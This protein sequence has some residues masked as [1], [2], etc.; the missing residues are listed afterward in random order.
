MNKF[1]IF[2]NFIELE[3]KYFLF[4][5]ANGR[6]IVLNQMIYDL[7]NEN[8][9]DIDN[10]K[11]IHP[12]L[13]ANLEKTGMIVSDDIDENESLISRLENEEN[14][15]EYF[16]IIINPTLDCNLRCWYC[17]ETHGHGTMMSTDVIESIKHLIDRKLEGHRLKHFNIGF[18]GGEPLLGWSKVV[19]PILTYAATK[20]VERGVTL[21]SSFTT[22]GVLLSDSKFDELSR[23]G[24]GGTSFQI[25]FD[26]H[27]ALHDISRIADI[28]HPT[29]DRIMENVVKGAYKGFKMNLRFNYT[30]ENID[31]F[32]NIITELE[33]LP[34]DIITHIACNFQQVWQTTGDT[35]VKDK[36]KT[37]IE[38]FRSHGIS[39]SSDIIYHRHVCYAD[40]PRNVVI[41]FNGDVYKCTAREFSSD[42]REGILTSEGN[43]EWNN[44]F[45]RRMAI[46][47]SNQTCRKC[48][49]LP[50]C[51]A[52]CS[53]N[54]LEREHQNGCPNNRTISSK[55]E[56]II[57]ALIEKLSVR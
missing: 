53:Q 27:R 40:S 37:L 19:M 48:E 52:G 33:R 41:N 46:K 45:H 11:S 50:I 8:R 51:N 49:I 28:A 5:I 2:A 14:N 55:K 17:Y 12:D 7:L 42:N 30:P 15:P 1:S 54:K 22:N 6:I 21:K 36:A 10:I 44:R 31:S 57:N 35:K 38:L 4:N 39:T 16:G 20:C 56:Y 29:Y 9:D 43:I 24:L 23:L 18:F 25:S 32:A 34:K 13:Y 47:F 26:G 3:S